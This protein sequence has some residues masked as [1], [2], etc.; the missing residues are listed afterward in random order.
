MCGI[1]G[2]L[3]F[4]DSGAVD[5][6]ILERM[7]R[8]LQHRGPD[9]HG[10]WNHGPLGLAHTRLSIVDLT[11]GVQP[12]VG[13][14]GR[15][16]ISFNGEIF[17]HV[18][19]RQELESYGHRFAT[20]H[21]DT[22]VILHAYQQ[23]GSDCVSRFNGQWAF[24]LWD[25][26]QQRLFLSRDRLGIR[27]LY[28]ASAGSTFLFGSEVKALFTHPKM[29]RNLYLPALSDLL[30]LW[31][32]L[33]GQTIFD[34]VHE[35]RPGHSMTVDAEGMN[36]HC[37]WQLT[38]SPEPP[39][40]RS[41]DDWAEELRSLL[42]DA[43]RL[44]LR[45]DVPVGAYLSGGLD[46]TVNA[47]MIKRFT[48]R[49]LCTFSVTF[50]ERDFDES[51][52]QQDAI[53][54]LETDHQEVHCR[55]RDIGRVFP[56]VIW[57]TEKPVFR[58]AP[59]PFYLLSKL[60]RESG[61]KVVLT[62]E[63]ADEMLG[64]YDI[65]KE[66]KIR[67]F[68][69]RY[70][71]SKL[72]PLLLKRLYPYMKNLQAQSIEYLK[73]FFHVSEQQLSHPLFSHLPRFELTRKTHLFFS[74][75]VK[76]EIS[77]RDPYDALIDQLPPRFF[78][79]QSFE[80]A[81]F[82]ETEILLPGYILSSQGDRMTMGHSVEGRFP[83]LDHR[84]AELQGRIPAQY[85][86]RVLDEK[87]VLKQATKDLIPTS[88]LKRPK[89]PYRAPDAQSFFPADGSP[90]PEYVRALLDE[91]KIKRT[92]LFNPRAVAQLVRKATGHQVVSVKD[93]MALLGILSTQLL[94]E[95]FIEKFDVP[96]P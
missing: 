25:L 22:E 89:Q 84:V 87:H 30:T 85:K 49:Q 54:H 70:P 93:N 96:L 12:M 16:V 14:Q 92:G 10:I 63:G 34:G 8:V 67:R 88:V 94:V 26:E 73:A 39:Q 50:E 44:R 51:T 56:D 53:R 95:A 3:D 19:L 37:Y 69:G 42:I 17:N 75:D 36:T 33:P 9:A 59:A 66:A 52:F 71:N 41:V 6:A 47:A 68:W 83:F 28:Y 58:T 45:A 61:F 65:F 60:V 40:A 11:G 27:P 2:I 24:A 15:L 13:V 90:P 18:E 77:Q 79:L 29:S 5:R 76:R 4:K 7:V 1:A 55:N 57:H 38:F 81:Q 72:R 31:A 64:G 78:E 62:G 23:W 86:M 80:Q 46:S 32:P 20:D 43:T 82:L 91:D 74:P 35:L 21:S 48:D